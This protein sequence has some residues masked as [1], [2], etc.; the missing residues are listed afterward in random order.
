MDF[1]M[2][3]LNQV[4]RFLEEIAVIL[5]RTFEIPDASKRYF[6]DVDSENRYYNAVNSLANLQITRGYKDGTFRPDRN[7]TRAEF[8]VFLSKTLAVESKRVVNI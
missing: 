8:S 5:K 4:F 2:I 6:T 1:L 7:I 3:Y